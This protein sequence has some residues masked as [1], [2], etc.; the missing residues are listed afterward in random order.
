M[1]LGSLA[2]TTDRTSRG[3]AGV[4]LNNVAFVPYDGMLDSLAYLR[5]VLE[6]DHSGIEKPAAIF[7]RPFKLK[8]V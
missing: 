5:W 8:V 2:L 4:P 1:S 7:W 3:G 6:D